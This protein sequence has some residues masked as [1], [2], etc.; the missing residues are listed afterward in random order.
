MDHTKAERNILEAIKV[1]FGARS[2]EVHYTRV[3]RDDSA[4]CRCV[5]KSLLGD[6][7]AAERVEGLV[8]TVFYRLRQVQ[9][10]VQ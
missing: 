1:R 5:S 6:T 2:Q 8:L 7:T 4:N 9:G 3:W 10:W